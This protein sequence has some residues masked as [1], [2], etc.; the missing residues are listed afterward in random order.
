MDQARNAR[1]VLIVG[2]G[3]TG[4]TAAV[5]LSRLGIDVR[6]V[7]RAAEPSSTSKALAVQARTIELLQPRG[8]G[9]AMLAQGT[10]AKGAS[11]YGRGK[12]LATVHFDRMPSRV[13]GV[14]LLPQS[15]TERLLHEQLQRQGI[16]VERGVELISFTQHESG[17]DAGVRAVLKHP[18][19]GEEVLDAAYLI[20]AEGAH[21]SVRHELGLSFDGTAIPQRYLLADLHLDGAMPGDELSIFLASDGFLAVFP[22]AERRFRLM[23]TDLGGEGSEG[24]GGTGGSV[25][26]DSDAPMLAELQQVVD[27]VAPISIRLRDLG[28]SSRF[29]INSRHLSTL[30]V[31]NVFLGG[32]AAHVH[33]PA[34]G[35][36]MNTGIQDMIN[37]CWKLALVAKGQARPALL[38]T[39][40]ADRLPLISALIRR[41]EAATK[42]FNSTNPLVHQLI[43]RAAPVALATDLVQNKANA[44]LGQIGVNYRDSPL[45]QTGG[46]VGHLRAGDRVPDLDVDVDVDVHLGLDAATV[47]GDR[48][49]APTTV[50]DLLDLAGLTL[51]VT[52]PK[53]DL[54]DVTERLRPWRDILTIRHVTIPAAQPELRGLDLQVAKDLVAHPS[55]LLIRPDAYIAA[56]ADGPAP[57]AAW[58]K[59][60]FVARE[61]AAC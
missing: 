16:E 28:W 42:A 59:A 47:A 45:T 53:A 29:F 60:W 25:P 55:L 24:G 35:Q 3:P 56:I 52:D 19:G 2:A 32:D 43:T 20:S 40:Q 17:P 37:L 8:V 12:L 18:D 4:L 14:L 10:K 49:S 33:S 9:A 61:G 50:Y 41:T 46:R 13:N 1:P 7:D 26:R 11:L 48:P 23:A 6:I 39:Y 15:A 54:A 31:G 44:V 38:D 21:S 58:L 57:I 34:G 30:R 51:L 36:G 22:L 5:E 27:R